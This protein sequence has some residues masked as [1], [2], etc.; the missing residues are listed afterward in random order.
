MAS[1]G[2]PVGLNF[3]LALAQRFGGV[4]IDPYGGYNFIVEIEGLLVGGFT[5]VSGLEGEIQTDTYAEG[6][7]NG[8]VRHFPRSTT[9][10]N[11]VLSHGLTD[12]STLWNWYYNV[13]RGVIERRNGTIMLLN[14]RSLPVMY[15]NFRNAMP[16]KWIGP[17][18]DAGSNEVAVETIELVHEGLVK[19]LLGQVAGLGLAGAKLAGG[20]AAAEVG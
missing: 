8:H 6:G 5:S 1:M 14:R 19:P 12:I 11:L 13:S 9:Y 2:L 3:G 10:P 18:F 16:V 4:R 7:V 20:D 17:T 15:W